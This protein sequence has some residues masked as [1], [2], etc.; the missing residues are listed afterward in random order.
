MGASKKFPAIAQ[1]WE[2]RRQCPYDPNSRS[3]KWRFEEAKRKETVE[4]KRSQWISSIRENISSLRLGNEQILVNIISKHLQSGPKAS[5]E[6]WIEEEIDSSVAQ[7]FLEGL[8][9]YWSTI[10]LPL[11]GS[12]YLSKEIPWWTTLV[13]LAVDKWLLKHGDNW[14]GLPPLMR[15][16]ALI[17]GLWELNKVPEWYPALVDIEQP[18]AGEL[19][20]HVF[21]MEAESEDAFPRL[22]NNLRNQGHHVAIRQIVF[23]YLNEHKNLHIQVALPMLQ[24]VMADRFSDPEAGHLWEIA[25]ARFERG[26]E[27]D[28]LRYFAA[29]W[30]FHPDRVW[31]WLDEQY[32]G[33]GE[34][35]RSRF[36]KWISAIEDIDLSGLYHALPVWVDEKTLISMLPDLYVTYPPET[37][38]TLEE[39]NTGN[40]DIQ[41]R[42]NLGHLRSNTRMRIL[43]SGLD[44]AGDALKRLLDTTEIQPYRD[45]LLDALDTWRRSH[46]A[47]SWIPLTPEQLWRV[48][49][50]SHTPVQNSADFFDLAYEILNEIRADIEKGEIPI[51]NLLWDKR[52]DTGIEPKDE[53]ALQ[54]LIANEIKKHPTVINQRLVSGRE[55]E[56]G[57][58]FPD[59]FITCILP[60]NR[61]SKIYIEVKRQQSGELLDAP[62]SQLAQKYIKDPEARYGFYLVGWYGE[63]RYKV[64]KNI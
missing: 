35:R 47:R 3:M 20:A 33:K 34:E 10:D 64:S 31:K 45:S 23:K 55:L 40:H 2:Q 59:I 15:Q 30:R 27:Q 63:G 38:P 43:E 22:A 41:R 11:V 26:D 50:N 56:V 6:K 62:S 17:A 36:D 57:G 32:L 28:A 29:L 51:R 12:E 16:K 19:F 13:L 7:A 14:M 53:R 4:Q 24:C 48:L 52:S 25:L 44:V 39:F 49:T 60:D 37:D 1:I 18:N 46:A 42:F 9:N 5:I 21:D 8:Q 54:I 58:N 61:R